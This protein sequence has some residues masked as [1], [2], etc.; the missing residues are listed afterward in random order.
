MATTIA[1]PTE[2]G[3]KTSLV[4]VLAANWWLILVRGV[5]A[6]MFGVLAIVVP[7]L[8]LV[9]LI[10]LI[11]AFVLVDG[12]FAV[13][14]GIRGGAPM[15]RW[16]LIVVGVAGI[17]TGLAAVFW[18]EMTAFLLII[19]VGF[20]AIVKGLFEIVG[21]VAVRK[22]IDNEWMLIFGGALSVLF[23]LVAVIAPGAGALALLWLIA[24]YAI[25]SGAMLIAFALRLRNVRNL[26]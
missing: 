14:A 2:F 10:Y 15:P 19:F 9:T 5:I 11:G 24:V 21:A 8:T 17:A 22:E 25:L 3:F 16:W 4:E 20:W 1:D 13:A 12:I 26:A 18:P 7:N 6:V 23:G